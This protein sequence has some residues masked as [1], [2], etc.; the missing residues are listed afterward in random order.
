MKKTLT[1]ISLLLAFVAGNIWASDY[2]DDINNASS[3][4]AGRQVI[5]EMNI[6]MFT[7]QGTFA[8]A[9]ERLAGLKTL[10][11]D[12]IW[13]MPVYPRGEGN[14]PY[15]ATDFRSTNPRYGTVADLKAFVA[16]AHELRMQVWLDWVPNHVA[17]EHP[18]V[19][20]HPEY[21]TNDAAGKMIHPHGW[22]DVLELNY[23]DAG[24]VEEMNSAL[25]FWIDTAD[26]DG[27]R[28]DYVSSPTIPV[29][30]WQNTIRM[31]KNYKPGKT[32]TFMSETDI[33][34]PD[35]ARIDS[36]GF[37]YDYAWWFQEGALK[38][39]FGAKGCVADSLKSLCQKF[40]ADSRTI[41]NRRMVYLTNH[42]Q[43]Y[44]D[45]GS[46][47]KD[48]YGDNRY[49]LTVLEFT[50][51]GMPL[52]YN[53]QEI[54]DNDI[55]DYFTD[56]KIDRDN[57][58]MKMYNTVRTLIALR[59]TQESL[60]DDADVTFLPT[61]NAGVLAYR[62]GDVVVVL[63][64]GMSDADV[65]IQGISSA[66]YTRWLDSRTI[67]EGPSAACVTLDPQTSVSIE[68]KGYAVYVKR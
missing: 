33:S 22:N 18:W 36:C 5:Y 42:D 56:S 57:C 11:V 65:R 64:V 17:V 2:V 47:M 16:R 49:A 7:P 68:S 3:A 32:I 51:Y 13:L 1:L 23:Q 8:A 54:G 31:L 66:G 67:A 62:R 61:D 35:N 59:H 27:F 26:V 38:H 10:G 55:L 37:D 34:N 9:G 39:R 6:G 58:D 25:K 12:V 4:T 63:N 44:N 48:M 19:E 46:T 52:L 21:F 28:C 60:S 45:G 15:A 50:L 40:L 14:S 53:G 29:S 20:S 43:N 30:Y 24:L 41:N